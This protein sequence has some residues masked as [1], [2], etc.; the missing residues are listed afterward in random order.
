[1]R[2][3]AHLRGWWRHW[4]RRQALRRPKGPLR[5]FVYLDEVS[6]YSLLASQLGPI[7]AEF[8]ET[9]TMSLQGDLEGSLAADM[10]VAK[11]EVKPRASVMHTRGSQVVK[12]SIV[13]TT[14]KELYEHV[15]GSL[16]MWP[17]A[18]SE[19]PPELNGSDDLRAAGNAPGREGWIVDPCDLVRGRLLE[20]EVQ[21]EA[22]ELFGVSAVTSALLDIMEDSPELFGFDAQRGLVQ[23][24]AIDRVL[25]KLLV[26]L[27]PVRGQATDYSVVPLEG[28]EWVVHRRA[29]QAWKGV[30]VLRT[31]P[32]YLVGLADQAHFWK[33]VRRVLFSKGRFRVLC[34]VAR[35]GLQDSW[36]PVPLARMLQTVAPGL[37]AE[38]GADSGALARAVQ[39]NGAGPSVQ[40]RQP[41]MSDVLMI[42]G[43]LLA[44]HYGGSIA[45]ED[46]SRHVEALS[47]LGFSSC[48]RHEER[49]AAFDIVGDF[50]LSRLGV[51]ADPTVLAECRAAALTN[52]G[53]DPFWQPL[54]V[55]AGETECRSVPPDMRFL[56]VEF[57]AIYW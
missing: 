34:R 8:T 13:Q 11:G 44:D 1:M 26:G 23:V 3:T 20:A 18:E 48:N 29:L 4:R 16:V 33:D 7:A 12:K 5:E 25:Q 35:E 22:E 41:S 50:V 14:F 54:M 9:Q 6:V 49:R 10:R 45:T 40:L 56:E 38:G 30:Q 15:T 55:P 37:A 39:A 53:L 52:A 21:L 46:L 47:Q 2:L 32:L 28:K 24:R 42:Y 36:N 31:R 51:Q 57:V 27:V 19:K 17:M 43:K